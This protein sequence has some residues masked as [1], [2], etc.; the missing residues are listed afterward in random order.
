MGLHLLR[1]VRLKLY[2]QD[3][4]DVATILLS[5]FNFI[6]KFVPGFYVPLRLIST[7]QT[8]SNRLPTASDCFVAGMS[9]QNLAKKS[10]DGAVD[11]DRIQV[12]SL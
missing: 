12:R 2:C 6:A 9:W 7:K 5:L 10:A 3:I 11:S 8:T 4:F 1:C